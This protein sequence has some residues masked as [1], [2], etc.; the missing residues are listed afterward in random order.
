MEDVIALLVLQGAKP[1]LAKSCRDALTLAL[2]F[3]EHDD[4]CVRECHRL[5]D[6]L[7]KK[8]GLRSSR[9]TVDGYRKPLG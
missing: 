7:D 9:K 6:C 5:G 4:G 8:G 2:A 1:C 3:G